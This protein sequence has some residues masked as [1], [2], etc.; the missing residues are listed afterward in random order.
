[1]RIAALAVLGGV[2]VVA[3]IL[4][5]GNEVEPTAPPSPPASSSTAS[6]DDAPRVA[7]SD[8]GSGSRWGK[9]YFPNIPLVTHEG[10][11]VRFFDDLIKDK[12]VMI[13]F[14]YT[15]CPDTCPLETARLAQVEKI[16]GDRVG[17]DVF[18]YSISIDPEHDTPEVLKAYAQRYQAGPGWLVLTGKEA[19]IINLRKKLGL[20]IQEIQ[21]GSNNHNL[22][23]IIGNQATGRWMK[24]SPFENPHV[25]ATHVGSWLH[26]WK[27][28]SKGGKDFATAPKLRSISDGER[29]FRTRCAA[30]HTLGGVVVGGAVATDVEGMGPDLMGVTKRREHAWL[31]RWIAEPDKMLEERDPIAMDLYAQYNNVPMPNMRLNELDVSALI[32]FIAVESSRLEEKRRRTRSRAVARAAIRERPQKGLIVKDAWIREAHPEAR[33]NAGYMTLHN[34]GP[35]ELVLVGVKSRAHDKAELHEMTMKD[36]MMDMRRISD[37]SIPPG[38]ETRLRPGA[39]HLMLVG[40]T[41]P[42][43]RGQKVSLT[44]VFQS[45]EE[46]TVAVPVVMADASHSP[47]VKVDNNRD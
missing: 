5:A 24:R 26:N 9:N 42:L 20:Y 29:L 39:K 3:W 46:Q 45:G 34:A 28:P 4:M 33:V 27:Q 23:L 11:K 22:S 2:C 17:R 12:V 15:S 1:M 30:C 8:P 7:S 13:N 47:G 16:L 35:E 14:I 10:K 19:D 6:S 40:A 43:T 38:G 37:L 31:A 25:L 36:G 41:R 21:D 32:E 18:M 44:L